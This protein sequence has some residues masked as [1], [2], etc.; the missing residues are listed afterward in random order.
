MATGQRKDF[1]SERRMS[2]IIKTAQRQLQ[3]PIRNPVKVVCRCYGRNTPLPLTKQWK[4][5]YRLILNLSYE[6]RVLLS[7]PHTSRRKIV[8]WSNIAP[9]CRLPFPHHCK[10]GPCSPLK[11]SLLRAASKPHKDAKSP[12]AEGFVPPVPKRPG[13]KIPCF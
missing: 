5:R 3:I 2:A 9:D 10:N 13:P 8:Y 11:I 1:L 12:S 7:I 6:R 4:S